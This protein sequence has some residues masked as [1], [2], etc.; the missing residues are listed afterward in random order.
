MSE[1]KKKK[2]GVRTI[3]SGEMVKFD[4]IFDI[5]KK[6]GDLTSTGVPS[7]SDQDIEC[8]FVEMTIKDKDGKEK[9]FVFNYLDIYMF[10]YFCAN[11]ELRQQ[12]QQRYERV[13]HQIPYDVTFK[14][15]D[16]EK[17]LGEAKRRIELPVDELIM[18]IARN[19][20]LKMR[21]MPVLPNNLRR[22]D[23]EAKAYDIKSKLPPGR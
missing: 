3:N 16:E 22:G 15:T 19:E 9:L 6:E 10:I 23:K 12:L 17:K 20:A 7:L 4:P 1:T 13:V 5:A 8:K 2:W 14:M 21:G 11:E 18:A